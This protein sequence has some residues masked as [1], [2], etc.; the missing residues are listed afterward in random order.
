MYTHLWRCINSF[1]YCHLF[2]FWGERPIIIGGSLALLILQP[3]CHF[4]YVTTH[5]PTLPSLYLRHSSFSQPSVASPTSQFILQPIFRFSYV[6]S[7]SL[8]SPGEPPMPIILDKSQKL[9]QDTPFD[10]TLYTVRLVSFRCVKTEQEEK[11]LLI[12]FS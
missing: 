9:Q 7:F 12:F 10:K 6:T 3:F 1:Q 2:K 11:V 8:N 5:S 4:T